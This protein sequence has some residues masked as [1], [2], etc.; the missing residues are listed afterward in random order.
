MIAA[1]LVVAAASTTPV[2]ATTNDGTSI[3]A[4][5][6][7]A[8]LRAFVV[9]NV[10]RLGESVDPGPVEFT[11][12]A[13]S[14]VRKRRTLKMVKPRTANK[15]RLR[16]GSS[17]VKKV[18]K[19]KGYTADDNTAA[20]PEDDVIFDLLGSDYIPAPVPSPTPPPPPPPSNDDCMSCAD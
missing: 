15:R 19:G 20:S 5:E 10:K 12:T 6:P 14:R 18:T 13:G 7:V 11:R 3:L 8:H 16:V 4:D 1:N 2:H 9:S 17:P